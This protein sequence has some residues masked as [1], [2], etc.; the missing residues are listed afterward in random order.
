[1]KNNRFHN[2]KASEPAAISNGALAGVNL[3]NKQFLMQHQQ[4]ISQER[5]TNYESS[6]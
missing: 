3:S 2:R 6:I 4:N 5:I 1:M